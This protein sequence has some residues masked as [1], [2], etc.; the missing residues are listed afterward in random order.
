MEY[1]KTLI[2]KR[3]LLEQDDGQDESEESWTFIGDDS[4]PE[5]VR[6]IM[7]WDRPHS[8]GLRGRHPGSSALGAAAQGVS[9]N[10]LVPP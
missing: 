8:P 6:R 2:K 10:A 4:D 5:L 9:P 7:E 3:A 1:A